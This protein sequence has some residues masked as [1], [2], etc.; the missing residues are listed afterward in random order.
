M[1]CRNVKPPFLRHELLQELE[2]SNPG[3]YVMLVFEGLWMAADKEGVFEW[4]PKQLHLDILPFLDFDMAKT[5]EILR[6]AGF[7]RRIG[8]GQ[9]QDSD[10]F[11]HVLNFRKH[12]LITGTEN[13]NPPKYSG[14][15]ELERLAGVGQVQGQDKDKT[16]NKLGNDADCQTQD[17]GIRTKDEGR[18]T[19][20][21]GGTGETP[22][23]PDAP[24][25]LSASAPTD[26]KPNTGKQINA[27]SKALWGALNGKLPEPD[28]SMIIS[29]C[30]PLNK[31]PFDTALAA[32]LGTPER[33]Q[34]LCK[35]ASTK[36]HPIQYVAKA[37]KG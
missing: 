34:D 13:I 6:Q 25:S 1:R 24:G 10:G 7:I 18:R 9:G 3:Q 14:L 35:E 11:G 27:N 12:Q 20:D 4:R 26:N 37:L 21:E 36:A 33:L 31:Q 22:K 19:Q 16:R 8:Q 29:L 15:K 32:A 5:L 28:I 2:K 30:A 17:E 23:E